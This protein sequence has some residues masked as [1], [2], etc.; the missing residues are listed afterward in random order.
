[1]KLHTSDEVSYKKTFTRRVISSSTGMDCRF[2][3]LVDRYALLEQVK[4]ATPKD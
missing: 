4:A 2:W 3:G 1:M